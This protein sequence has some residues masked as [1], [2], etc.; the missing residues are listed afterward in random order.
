LTSALSLSS[1]AVSRGSTPAT[2]FRQFVQTA[3]VEEPTALTHR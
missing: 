1:L 3:Y 2:V